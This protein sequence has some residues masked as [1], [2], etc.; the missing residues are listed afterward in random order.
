[1]KE[2]DHRLLT[3]AEERRYARSRQGRE[4]LVLHNQRLVGSVARG[5]MGMG[6]PFEDLCQEG[7]L[8]LIRAA[9][10]FDPRRRRRFTTMATW[11][12]RL[13]IRRAIY[14]SPHIRI[15]E[16]AWWKKGAR[17]PRV[18][19]LSPAFEGRVAPAAPPDEAETVREILDE[20]LSATLTQRERFILE[21]RCVEGMSLVEIGEILEM[22]EK[23]VRGVLNRVKEKLA[24]NGRLQELAQ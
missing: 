9:R 4:L 3:A 13:A 1:M 24:G 19:G 8:G 14:H 6:L 16:R 20:E 17:P 2:F 7:N 18:K 5:F 15:S 10:K 22:P 11:W 23:R 21:A 12:I